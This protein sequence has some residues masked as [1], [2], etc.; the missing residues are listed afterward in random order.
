MSE[1]LETIRDAAEQEAIAHVD[2][3]LSD[4]SEQR[5]ARS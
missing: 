1:S 2:K 3:W 4:L 5:A